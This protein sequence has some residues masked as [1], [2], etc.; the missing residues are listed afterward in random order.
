MNMIIVTRPKDIAPLTASS[1]IMMNTLRLLNTC[2]YL[3]K[4]N[5]ENRVIQA[6]MELSLSMLIHS[7]Q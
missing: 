5:Q 3:R 4:H 6:N 7:C 1:M 2:K